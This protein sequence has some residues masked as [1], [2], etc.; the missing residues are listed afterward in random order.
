MMRN[1]R[2]DLRRGDG[3]VGALNGLLPRTAGSSAASVGEHCG[4]PCLASQSGSINGVEGEEGADVGGVGHPPHTL[5]MRMMAVDLE[6]L[7]RRL[8]PAAMKFFLAARDGQ[9]AL[10]RSNPVTC[11]GTTCR[12]ITAKSARGR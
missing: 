10:R 1:L 8:P 2:I 11:V 7:G 6:D 5:A 3:L 9:L 12:R 4:R